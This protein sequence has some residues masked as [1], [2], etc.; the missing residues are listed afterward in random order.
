MA[1]TTFVKIGNI[2]NLSDARYCA[3]MMADVL[4]FN[5]QPESPDYISPESFTEITNWLSGVQFAGEFGDLD[6]DSLN[7]LLPTYNVDIL[8]VTNALTLLSI[9]HLSQKKIFRINA[10]T[11][12]SVESLPSVLEAVSAHCDWTTIHCEDEKLYDKIESIIWKSE[13]TDL[14]K[15]Y[16]INPD[17][18]ANMSSKWCGIVLEGSPEDQ[19]GYKDYGIVMDVL[20]ALEDD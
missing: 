18:V 2:S 20:E 6:A 3:G 1:L 16:D 13:N 12:E 10:D 5:L 19:P 17:S 14:L 11:P 15:G 9:S 7:L 8:E 4:G